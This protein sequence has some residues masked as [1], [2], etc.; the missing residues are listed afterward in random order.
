M[1]LLEMEMVAGYAQRLG[2]R[3]DIAGRR[4]EA[5]GFQVGQQLAERYTKDRNRFTDLIE[6]IKFVCKDFWAQV[7]R[8]QVD[9][10]RTNH[11]GVFVLQDNK[12]R[13]FTRL[14]ADPASLPTATAGMLPG[15]SSSSSGASPP[16]PPGA[17]LSITT[18][19][20][21]NKVTAASLAQFLYFPCGI[22]RGALTSLGV[23]CT[24]S[25]EIVSLPTC[26][27]TVCIKA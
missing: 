7:F 14:S 1:E 24:V 10:L 21:Y 4:I 5:I 22:I 13:W 2:D 16:R 17:D 20:D 26:S 25:G 11:R 23:P 18:P 9:N 8:K 15:P 12:F 19:H 27:F 3:P 6:I